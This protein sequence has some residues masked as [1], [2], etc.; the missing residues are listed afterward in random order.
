MDSQPASIKEQILSL[1]EDDLSAIETELDAN[2]IPWQDLVRDAAGHILFAGGKRLRPLLLLVCAK[3]CGSDAPQNRR[4]STIFEYLH[5]ATL[6]HDDLVDGAKLRRG[7][8]AAQHVFGNEIAV[9]TGDFLLARALSIAADTNS[10]EVIRVIGDIT[11]QMSQGEIQQ[12]QDKGRID[13]SEGE[14]LETIRRKTAVLMEGA[15]YVG[16]LVAQAGPRE[17]ETLQRYGRL[18]GMAFQ[19]ADDLLDYTSDTAALGKAAGADLREGKLT[20]PVIASLA[21]A[22]PEDRNW[23]TDM[24]QSETFTETDFKRF[25][26][27]LEK[28]GGIARTRENAAEYVKE[29]KAC[30]DIFPPSSP[31]TLLELIATYALQRKA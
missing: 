8:P 21:A 27:L 23:M 9:L 24:I 3:I 14:Y 2:L 11:E 17:A 31:K 7:K 20:L 19:M 4:F 1:V 30:L 13:L 15:C 5:A 29:A 12:L 10:L 16:A 22:P 25:S 6:L 18:I 28:H 26:E